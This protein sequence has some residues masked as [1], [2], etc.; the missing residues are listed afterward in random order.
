MAAPKYFP[1][2]YATPS[3]YGS[4]TSPPYKQIVAGGPKPTPIGGGATI[5]DISNPSKKAAQEA[6]YKGITEVQPY[7][8][9]AAIGEYKSATELQPAKTQQQA[10][11]YRNALLGQDVAYRAGSEQ[12]L[13]ENYRRGQQTAGIDALIAA[14]EQ[15][16]LWN[17][18]AGGL[19][20]PIQGQDRS[21]AAYQNQLAYM[22]KLSAMNKANMAAGK[23][24]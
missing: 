5:V 1:N 17:P 13:R 11:E 7:K 18:K 15:G 4:R 24:A 6:E 2:L 3:N 10:G 20:G 14:G 21:D 23:Y 8:T 19:T 22:R 9:A 16:N 12:E